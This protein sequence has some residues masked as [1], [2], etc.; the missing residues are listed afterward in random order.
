M[1]TITDIINELRAKKYTR[2]FIIENDL[3]KCKETDES[4]APNEL[5]IEEIHRFEGDS[6]PDDMSIIYAINTISGTRG[7]IIDAYGTYSNPQI[8]AFIKDVPVREEADF[9][10]LL[11]LLL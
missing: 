1:N 2:D 3:L 8:S 9:K 4:F 7:L 6:N 5:I 10:I 11:M